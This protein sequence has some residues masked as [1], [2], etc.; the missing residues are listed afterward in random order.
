MMRG[1]PGEPVTIS[2][3]PSFSTMVG[4]IDDSGLLRGPGALAAPPT[5]PKA[6]GLPGLAAKSSSSLLSSTPVPSATSPSP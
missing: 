6:L 3:L 1:P 4:V 5:S 2:G